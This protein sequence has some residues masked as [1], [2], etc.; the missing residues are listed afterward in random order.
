MERDASTLRL[1][2]IN[3]NDT[4]ATQNHCQVL[5]ESPDSHAQALVFL[6]IGGNLLAQLGEYSSVPS[7]RP[8]RATVG[9]TKVHAKQRTAPT[10]AGKRNHQGKYAPSHWIPHQLC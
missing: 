9:S 2:P 7:L 5:F 6:L 8:S 1:S 3:G 10:D 4:A